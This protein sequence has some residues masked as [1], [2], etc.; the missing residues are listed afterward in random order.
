MENLNETQ[1]MNEEKNPGEPMDT[2]APKELAD[3]LAQILD[4]KKAF[5]LSVLNVKGKTDICDYFV[6]ATGTSNTHVRALA[7]ELEIQTSR[8]QLSPFHREG[9]G[10]NTWI[11][12]DYATVI[13]HIFTRETREFYHLDKLYR[14]A[15]GATSSDESV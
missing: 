7:D 11:V 15:S 13:V 5:Q 6:L 12:L 4:N 3:A 9:R 10:G 2:L 14:E 8:R 1:T